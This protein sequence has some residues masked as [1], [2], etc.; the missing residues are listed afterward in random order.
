MKTR[1]PKN[2]GSS[3]INRDFRLRAGGICSNM[4][5]G[6][7]ARAL[8]ENDTFGGS[9]RGAGLNTMYASVTAGRRRH[10]HRLA[11][12][13]ALVWSTAGCMQPNDCPP[14]SAAPAS[15]PASCPTAVYRGE[16]NPYVAGGLVIRQIDI[17][18]CT[19]GNNV[20]LLIF[21]PQQPAGYPVVVY[22]HGF[23]TTNRA[24]SDLLTHVASHGFVVV[25]PQM[26]PPGLAALLSSPSAAQEAQEL[27]RV[28]RWLP[29]ELPEAAGY[30]PCTQRVG[31]A[32]HSRGGAVAWMVLS[33]DPAAA[34][35]IAGVDPVGFRAHRPAGASQPSE[36]LFPF[37][38]PALVIGAG[39]GGG[40]APQGRN[41]E[42]FYAASRSPAWHVIIPEAGHADML[43]DASAEAARIVCPGGPD[44]SAARRTFAGL[45]VAF[46]RA[47]LQDDPD[48]CA[49][50]QDAGAAP[51]RI[52]VES[53]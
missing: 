11:G 47:S 42:A 16:G 24:Y 37:S 1:V 12:L 41:H 15:R 10:V 6:K 26:Y 29:A 44:R 53:K 7:G 30:T 4:S 28:L 18:A 2:G 17:P 5:S 3:R 21:A 27:A 39:L 20:P 14:A 32:G 8:A 50:L 31:L 13:M 49:Y 52:E 35:A 36:E 25:V 48:A 19:R 33:A 43:D 34:Q 38:L 22:D 46:F 40:C 23:V 51:L 9:G 45:M